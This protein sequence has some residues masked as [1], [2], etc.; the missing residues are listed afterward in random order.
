[1][2]E[3][4]MMDTD[5]D[6]NLCRLMKRVGCMD[7]VRRSWQ[8]RLVEQLEMLGATTPP[9]PWDCTTPKRTWERLV[10]DWRKELNEIA[11]VEGSRRET[12][13]AAG[14]VLVSPRAEARTA[15][16]IAPAAAPL[17]ETASVSAQREQPQL[18]PGW[19]LP[20]PCRVGAFRQRSAAATARRADVVH[21]G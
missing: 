3:S 13:V 5:A 16:S 1:M 19:W 8:Y 10:Q 6:D 14:L 21:L 2:A 4:A 9:N 15:S 7:A 11:E 20:K 18:P 12:E 17:A